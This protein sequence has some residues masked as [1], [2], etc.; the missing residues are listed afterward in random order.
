[1]DD[2]RPVVLVSRGLEIRDVRREPTPVETNIL[3]R[4]NNGVAAERLIE[5]VDRVRQQPPAALRI[6]RWPKQRHELVA[7]AV[8]S[9]R[10]RQQRE[11]CD[12]VALRCATGDRTGRRVER[13][14]QRGSNDSHACGRSW[15]DTRAESEANSAR[16][17]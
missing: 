5:P 13:G 9:L 1:M 3:G 2:A 6:G 11:K 16:L 7:A 15:G 12:A 4:S 17:S 10:R 14:A 8:Q